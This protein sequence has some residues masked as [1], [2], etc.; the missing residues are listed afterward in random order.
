MSAP[1]AADLALWTWS[2]PHP[3]DGREVAHLLVTPRHH[4]RDAAMTEFATGLGLVALSASRGVPPGVPAGRAWGAVAPTH[5][6]P[7]VL[8]VHPGGVVGRPVDSGW[9]A[10]A[11]GR[12][13]LVLTVGT[14]P[15]PDSG[16]STDT[17]ATVDVPGYVTSGPLVFHGLLALA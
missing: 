17:G 1:E 6:S 16:S 12:R 14:T 13:F 5:R 4:G 8:L 3:D 15:A 11:V 10:T 9:R 7:L 2:A